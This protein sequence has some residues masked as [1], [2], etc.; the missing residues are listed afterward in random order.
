[1]VASTLGM[2]PGLWRGPTPGCF[3]FSLTGR[4]A[5][6]RQTQL[7]PSG[8]WNPQSDGCRRCRRAFCAGPWR[9]A[10]P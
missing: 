3:W 9:G 8:G 7:G 1:M 5:L 2:G 4:P 10:G 6:G